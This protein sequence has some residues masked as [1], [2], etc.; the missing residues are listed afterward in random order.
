M[1]IGIQGGICTMSIYC[2]VVVV[3]VGCV[4]FVGFGHPFTLVTEGV[5]DQLVSHELLSGSS[6]LLSL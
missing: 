1:A 3:A 5:R 4:L 2:V 6:S